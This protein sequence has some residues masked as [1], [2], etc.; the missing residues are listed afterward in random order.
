V[1]QSPSTVK[2]FGAAAA[3]ALAGQSSLDNKYGYIDTAEG[4]R[5]S[6]YGYG[7]DSPADLPQLK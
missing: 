1:A 6:R 5:S 2:G 4:H 7:T 3:S